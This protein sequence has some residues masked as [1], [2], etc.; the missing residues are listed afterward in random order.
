MMDNFD[1]DVALPSGYDVGFTVIENELLD[2]GGLSP[3]KKMVLLTLRRFVG[4]VKNESTGKIEAK[5]DPAWPSLNN[6]A[7]KSG[8]SKPTVIKSLDFFEWM[9]W[10]ERIHTVTG[11]GEK[12]VNKYILKVPE[13]KMYLKI[14]ESKKITFEEIEEYFNCLYQN[15]KKGGK[16][17]LDK[18][19]VFISNKYSKQLVE[20]LIKPYKKPPK[21]KREVKK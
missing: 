4:S 16:A 15:K 5:T 11:T 10:I 13:I 1:I 19:C 20:D 8:I 18:G 2:I 17:L 21:K 14:F 9:R 12:G 7:F 3:E 6:L